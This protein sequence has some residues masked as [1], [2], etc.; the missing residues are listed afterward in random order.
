MTDYEVYSKWQAEQMEVF[1]RLSNY[2]TKDQN[3]WDS[4]FNDL[5]KQSPLQTIDQL[6]AEEVIQHWD[7]IK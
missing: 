7:W 6:Y 2:C 1:N 4:W 5:R 3:Q